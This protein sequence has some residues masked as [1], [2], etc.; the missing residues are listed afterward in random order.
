M[1]KNPL[2]KI[3]FLF[4]SVAVVFSACKKDEDENEVIADFTISNNY[5][6][7]PSD[8]IF[9]NASENG[10]SYLWDFGDGNTATD[11]SPTHTYDSAG[12]YTVS[13]TTTGADGSKDTETKTVML[14]NTITG[15]SID[16]VDIYQEAYGDDPGNYDG[17]GDG[18]EVGFVIVNDNGT[19]V[20]NDEFIHYVDVSFSDNMDYISFFADVDDLP[21]EIPAASFDET[22][23]LKVF[24]WDASV[25]DIEYV[26]EASFKV[27]DFIVPAGSYGI[28][29]KYFESAH[30]AMQWDW[31]DE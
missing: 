2:L 30:V 29:Y 6:V 4:I 28:F 8:V 18:P 31:L 17:A 12:R 23:T 3:L 9:T 22:Y 10:N 21:F 16:G 26:S 1:K 5:T 7:A 14:F 20:C 11:A 27:S 24:E 13:L 15:I 19:I 25:N